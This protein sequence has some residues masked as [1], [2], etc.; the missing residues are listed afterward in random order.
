MKRKNLFLS[1]FLVL[2]VVLTFASDPKN[3]PKTKSI[4]NQGVLPKVDIQSSLDYLNSLKANPS[5]GIVNP[6]DILKAR[7]QLSQLPKNRSLSLSWQSVGPYGIGGRTRAILISKDNSNNV[8]AGSCGGGLFKSNDAGYTWN[9]LS[10]SGTSSLYN[11][12][13]NLDVTCLTQAY[14]GDIYF[15]T[16]EGIKVSTFTY[17]PSTTN[18][19]PSNYDRIIGTVGQGIWKSVDGGSTFTQLTSTIPS[20]IDTDATWGYVNRIAAD[21]RSGYSNRIYAATNKGLMMSDNGGTTWIT[22]K[23]NNSNSLSAFSSDVKVASDGTVVCSVGNLLY[24]STNGDD[25]TYILKSKGIDKTTPLDSLPYKNVGRIEI[26]IAPSDAN[27]IYCSLI[28]NSPGQPNHGNLLNIYRSTDKGSTW[29]VIGP[30]G[31]V[32]FNPYN[33][34]GWYANSIAVNP[35]NKEIIVFGGSNMWQWQSGQ[36][37]EQISTFNTDIFD[38]YYLHTNQHIYVYDNN[39][40]NVIYIGSD[41]GISK[42]INGGNKFTVMNKNYNTASVFAFSQTGMLDDVISGTR[43]NGATYSYNDPYSNASSHISLPDPNN[44]ELDYGYDCGS[45][46]LSLINPN[47]KLVSEIYGQL[48]RSPDG[49]QFSAFNKYSS[50]VALSANVNSSGYI[51]PLVMWENYNN[52]YSTDSV[53]F[54]NTTTSTDTVGQKVN[55]FSSNWI[56]SQNAFPFTHTLTNALSAGDSIKVP[57]IISSKLFVG[58][59]GKI[60]Y[61]KDPVKFSN[62]VTRWAQIQ[63]L[64]TV[65]NANN[66]LKT[67]YI[68]LALSKNGNHLFAGTAGGKIY[69]ISGLLYNDNVKSCYAGKSTYA[70]NVSLIANFGN[71]ISTGTDSNRTVT[72]IS[73]DPNDTNKI[74]ITLGSYGFSDYIYYSSNA[75]DSAVTFTSKQASLPKMPV[76]S[77]LILLSNSNTALIGT[78]MGVFSTSDLND[79]NPIWAD[80]NAGELSAHLPVTMIRQQTNPGSDPIWA[81]NLGVIYISTLGRGVYEAKDYLSVQDHKKGQSTNNFNLEVYPNPASNIAIIRFNL[82]KPSNVTLNICDIQ[83]RVIESSKITKQTIGNNEYKLDCSAFSAG[84]YLIQLKSDSFTKSSKLVIIK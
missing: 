26:A 18:P 30:G 40:S 37:P 78:D 13:E 36:T 42:T 41:G 19:N 32:N 20:S 52:I 6:N 60:Y 12:V 43:G 62:F 81:E 8:F 66:P 83:G 67:T 48:Y 46:G 79:A 11:N 39:N 71:K 82:D 27:Y 74:I 2:S 54:K 7:T 75:C 58:V 64:D 10:Y 17:Y 31:S 53:W 5:T 34:N 51:A 69:R 57:D 55:C 25:G 59:N 77:S 44:T 49:V 73:T 80:E 3:D 23:D 76:Y 65:N 56:D 29:E 50:G 45:V 22:V 63:T 9:K 33:N 4:P 38:N 72:S 70:L 68:S 16:G 35:T 21:P 28:I 14:N 15:G 47:M 61:T 84:T 24:I 1:S